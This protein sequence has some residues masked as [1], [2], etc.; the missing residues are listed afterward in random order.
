MDAGLGRK[1]RWTREVA[2]SF[3][4]V[5]ETADSSAPAA[6]CLRQGRNDKTFGGTDIESSGIICAPLRG[7]GFAVYVSADA[8]GSR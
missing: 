4:W 7:R 1:P 8:A 3:S 5:E 6:L 2:G